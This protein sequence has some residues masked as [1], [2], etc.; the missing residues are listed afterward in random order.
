M[1]FEFQR[2]MAKLERNLQLLERSG[3]SAAGLAKAGLE[4]CLE[5]LTRIQ[6][7]LGNYVFID[8]EKEILF[9]KEVFPSMHK[10]FLYFQEVYRMETE[11]PVQGVD[12]T[13]AYYQHHRQRVSEEL[14]KL[15]FIHQ[16]METQDCSQDERLFTRA[17]RP[18]VCSPWFRL[19][20]DYRY[21]TPGTE[22]L[23]R[24]YA[25]EML[26]D[27]LEDC[28]AAL[29]LAEARKVQEADPAFSSLPLHWTDTKSALIELIY[30]LHL[31]GSINHGKQGLRQLMTHF[32]LLFQMPLGNFYR[33]F[34]SMKHRKQSARFLE[35]LSQA[36]RRQLEGGD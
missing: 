35:R 12:S 13:E 18:D 2:E 4:C 31:T 24:Y 1:I 21:G 5:S 33:C 26:Y 17:G 25:L 15:R 28:L 36:L 11:K 14:E 22:P 6:Q 34:Q 16:Y 9:F 32:E 19:D 7:E 3:K 20:V 23:A 30:A 27:Y 29:R 10:K 8:E